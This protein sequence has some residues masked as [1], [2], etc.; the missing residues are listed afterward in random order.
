MAYHDLR[1]FLSALERGGQLARVQESVDPE[2]E[3]TA[4]SLAA[5]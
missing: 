2:L 5:L 4:L 3:S 1:A